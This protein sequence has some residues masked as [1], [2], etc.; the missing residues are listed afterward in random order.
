M[1]STDHHMLHRRRSASAPRLVGTGRA[2]PHP[3]DCVTRNTVMQA[4]LAVPDLLV[5]L[6]TTMSRSDAVGTKS[7]GGRTSPGGREPILPY[8]KGAADARALLIATLGRV[9]DEVAAVIGRTAPVTARDQVFFLSAELP[10]L[11]RGAAALVGIGD[12]TRAVR[13]AHVAIDRPEVR[14]ALGRCA[15][16]VSLYADETHDVVGCENC[17]RIHSAAA[18]RAAAVGRAANKL[19]TAAQLARML[20]WIGEIRIT[21]DRIRQWAVRGKLVAHQVD[22]QSLYRVGDVLALATARR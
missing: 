5:E 9:V 20:P 15:C 12:I 3:P 22:G 10:K 4:L 13:T 14:R 11:P 18:V 2:L 1:T 16:G 6:D 7:M 8:N 17:G 21:A 19:A